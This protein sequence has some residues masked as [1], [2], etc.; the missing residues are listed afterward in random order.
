MSLRR[1][2]RSNRPE[3]N[4]V[5][6]VD[7]LMVLI[8]F[9]L[10]TMQF[11]E[12]RVL[13]LRLPE[14]ETAGTTDVRQDLRLTID[15]DGVFYLNEQQVNENQLRQGLRLAGQADPDRRV[16]LIVHEETPIRLVARVMDW[17]RQADL[18]A[19][20]IQSR[21]VEEEPAELE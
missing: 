6:L 3:V 10:M 9:F 1:K 12:H 21:S 20:R 5:P 8:F 7:V 17:S 2:R 4:I 14:I 16:L 13:N 19:V 11:R 15:P 18:N